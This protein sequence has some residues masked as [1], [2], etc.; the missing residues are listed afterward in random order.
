MTYLLTFLRIAARE[1]KRSI[2]KRQRLERIRKDPH[3]PF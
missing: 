3:F 1:W 2:W